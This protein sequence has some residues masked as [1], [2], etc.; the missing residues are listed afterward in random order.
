MNLCC[1]VKRIGVVCIVFFVLPHLVIASQHNAS[2]TEV[3]YTAKFS[4]ADL[5]YGKFYKYD[6]IYMKDAGVFSE[7][8]K[9]VLPKMNLRIAIPAR[10]EV[11]AV[12][13]KFL[14]SLEIPGEF[15]VMPGQ[16]PL[17]TSVSDS[18]L[19]VKPDDDVYGSNLP[20]PDELVYFVLQS[21]LA[22]QEIVE[23][24]VYPLQYIPKDKKLILH[25]NV[26]LVVI[27]PVIAPPVLRKNNASLAGN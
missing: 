25:T 4:E 14:N 24:S 3:R 21:D 15:Y 13:S 17:K 8:G 5:S 27:A 20:Y 2:I 9:P 16:P 10:T 22:G 1:L 19:L 23:I 6:L 18:K 26:E 7:L 11:I 12:E